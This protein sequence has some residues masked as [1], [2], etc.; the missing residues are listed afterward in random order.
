[1]PSSSRRVLNS[2]KEEEV[3]KDGD[4]WLI[5]DK[6]GPPNGILAPYDPNQHDGHQGPGRG[7]YPLRAQ[8]Q[9]SL[10]TSA[11]D[12]MPCILTMVRTW[13][14]L[15][16]CHVNHALAEGSRAQLLTLCWESPKRAALSHFQAGRACK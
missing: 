3:V 5:S 6:A 11:N 15:V 13:L 1:M 14:G 9:E 12:F 8:S 10:Q 2:A 7:R 16:T 4:L